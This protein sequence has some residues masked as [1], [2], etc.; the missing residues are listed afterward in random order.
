MSPTRKQT[1]KP[2]LPAGPVSSD[3]QLGQDGLS[4]RNNQGALQRYLELANV[5][6]SEHCNLLVK[7]TDVCLQGSYQQ[8]PLSGPQ[9]Q[10]CNRSHHWVKAELL[11]L[12]AFQLRCSRMEVDISNHFFLAPPLISWPL[13]FLLLFLIFLFYGNNLVSR[14][15]PFYLCSGTSQTKKGLYEE[16]VS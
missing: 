15:S 5:Y 12:A 10:S 7:V 1:N 8:L 13:A 2:V 6:P 9:S 3:A 16:C 4:F 11:F 14:I